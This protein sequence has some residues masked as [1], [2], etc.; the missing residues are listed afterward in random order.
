MDVLRCIA[1]LMVLFRH[2]G[3]ERLDLPAW[4]RPT[5]GWLHMIGWAGVDFF[6][7]LSGFLVSGL[8]F[9]EWRR[10][11]SLAPGRFLLRRALKIYPGFWVFLAFELAYRLWRHFP[12]EWERFGAEFFFVQNYLPGLL[13][14]TWSLAVEEHFYLLLVAALWAAA[15][16]RS[17]VADPFR[18]LPWAAVVIVVGSL[19][20][21]WLTLRWHGVELYLTHLRLDA[22][23]WGTLL[24][25]AYHFHGERL[26]GALA[27]RTP[28]LLATAA[29]CLSPT[30]TTG[31]VENGFLYVFGLT[32]NLFAFGLIL[33]VVRYR[34]ASIGSERGLMMRLAAR[35]GGASYAIYLWHLTWKVRVDFQVIPHTGPVLGLA[36]YLGG[37]VVVGLLMTWLVEW[38]VLRL[39]ERFFPSRAAA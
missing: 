5:V 15:R 18:W 38:P 17:G 32:G 6:F 31:T 22:F 16:R 39:R 9:R 14:H 33:L 4:L 10:H 28:W 3:R 37:S 26:G 21:R 8:L 25:Y 27:G 20:A 24:A 23:A 13:G 7:V 12:V 19:V 36:I 11:G 1:V 29:V 34:E 2:I 30:L 35:I